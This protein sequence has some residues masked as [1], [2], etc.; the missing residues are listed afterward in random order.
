MGKDLETD[1]AS[2]SAWTAFGKPAPAFEKGIQVTGERYPFEQILHGSGKCFAFVFVMHLIAGKMN[3]STTTSE[4][5]TCIAHGLR[6]E[7]VK[8]RKLCTHPQNGKHSLE[9]R[10]HW[11]LRSLT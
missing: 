7:V 6:N 3:I 9:K 5:P 11:R 1:L 2:C 4:L 10:N 8:R